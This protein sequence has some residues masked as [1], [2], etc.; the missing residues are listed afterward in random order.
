MRYQSFLTSFFLSFNIL[1]DPLNLRKFQALK[2]DK[3]EI[4]R[5]HEQKTPT[6]ILLYPSNTL[7]S[8]FLAPVW[9]TSRRLLIVSLID[10]SLVMSSL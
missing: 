1:D 8:M 9:T 5:E 4:N 10:S 6:V 7:I 3:T 2:H